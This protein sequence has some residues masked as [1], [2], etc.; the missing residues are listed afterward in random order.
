MSSKKKRVLVIDALNLYLR[1]YIIAPYLSKD[2]MPIGGVIGT[3]KSL[4]KLVRD[5][6]PDNV[7]FAWDGPDG[8]RKRKILNK[9][10]KAGRKPLRL[11]RAYD[12][13]SEDEET[14]NKLWQQSR[15][16]EYLNIM[17][18]I[19]VMLPEIEADDV[20]SHVVQMSHYKNWQKIIVSN[21][22]DFMQLC[23]DETLL[24]R[25]V[26]KE[27]LN[28][29]RI[30]EQTGIH[31]VNMALARAVIGDSSDNLPGIRGV[32]FATVAK[33]LDF[34]SEEKTYT[35]DEVMEHCEKSNTK[36]KFFSNVVEGR[37]IIEHNYKMMQLYS[38]MM[39]IQAKQITEISVKDF[40]YAFNKTELIKMM[41]EDGFLELNLNDLAAGMNRIVKEN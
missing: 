32:G 19:Q 2:G 33:R 4:Q 24:M 40:E 3:L 37:E 27:I 35:I 10:Y 15:L 21:D 11:N 23:D 8:S 20:I 29:N 36:L 30:V 12:N 5:T 25:P 22:K 17:P 38:P 18:V 13:L 26:K 41:N 9:D 16:M 14:Q 6:Q 1:S 28:K 31:P 39:S 34:L 7:I